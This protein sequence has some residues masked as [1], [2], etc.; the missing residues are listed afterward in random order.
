MLAVILPII[1]GSSP[2]IQ[3]SGLSTPLATDHL[4]ELQ[5][6]NAKALWT[7]PIVSIRIIPT[8]DGTKLDRAEVGNYG[9]TVQQ[10]I[11]RIDRMEYNLKFIMEE[12]SRYHG[13]MGPASLP[14][15][16]VRF[17]KRYT[18]YCRL[19]RGE[20][21]DNGV[22]QPDY[23]LILKTIGAEQWVKE[24]GVKEFWVWG[25]HHGDIAPVESAMS[26]PKGLELGNGATKLSKFDKTY[27]VYGLNFTRGQSMVLHDRIHTYERLLPWAEQ[28][29]SNSS[30][31]WESFVGLKDGKFVGGRVGDCHH[32]PNAAKDYDYY[33]ARFASS[34][35]MDWKPE[36][37]GLS[38]V[39]NRTWMGL[40]YPWPLSRSKHGDIFE[41]DD[42]WYV[43]WM[44]NVPG[45]DFIESKKGQLS[46]WWQLLADF[47]SAYADKM[48]LIKKA[49]IK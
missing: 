18:F 23:E 47:D 48:P 21:G 45:R 8:S 27:Y 41:G 7:I 30:T 14:S 15:V 29:A 19:P 17:V 42:N 24:A 28:R 44:Q 11:S 20:R 40:N 22:Y 16:G 31:I 38:N 10:T 46:N 1:L 35:I 6:V 4:S 2:W 32:P 26:N 25:Y 34:D 3:N 43:F 13:Y 36:G 33:N 39:N 9:N 37:G 49:V 5:S 12:A